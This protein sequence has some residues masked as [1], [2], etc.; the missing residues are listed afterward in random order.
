MHNGLVILLSII[1]IF[2]FYKYYYKHSYWNTVPVSTCNKCE[3]YNVHRSHEDKIEAANIIKEI[4]NRNNKLIE[5]LKSKYLTSNFQPNMDNIKNNHIDVVTNSDIFP[6][7]AD[8]MFDPNKTAQQLQQ[9]TE[10]EYLHERISQLIDY[11][12]PKEIYEIS[13]L[14]SSGVTSYTQNKKTLILCLRKKEKN[15]NN[16]NELHDINTIMFVVIHELSH[17]MNNLW[18]HKMNFWVLFKFMLL[19][20]VEC[21]IYK[22]VNYAKSPIKYCGLL[23]SYSPLFDNVV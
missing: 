16:E 21:G 15:T 6:W 9:V 22:P 17:M 13:P 10:S 14:N 5:H 4:T 7:T 23:I 8:S 3:K 19:N 20:S 11:Y 1:L 12:N 18:G 2:L